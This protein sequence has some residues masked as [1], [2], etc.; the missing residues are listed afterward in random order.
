[1]IAKSVSIKGAG[2]KPGS[3][4]RKAVGLTS[5]G[6]CRVSDEGLGELRGFP[7]V[8][9]ESAEGGVGLRCQIEGPNG[10]LPAKG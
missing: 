2:R 9:Q 4:A 6:L 3:C 10:A 5:G 8:A 7:N 1:M